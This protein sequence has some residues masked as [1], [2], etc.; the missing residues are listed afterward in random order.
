MIFV[1]EPL[2]EHHAP[3]LIAI[4]NHYVE[5]SFAAYP[6]TP[7]PPAAGAR[8]IEMIAGYPALVALNSSGEVVGFAFLRPWHPA[9]VFRRTAE[10]TYFVAPAQ[11]GQ[12]LGKRFLARLEQEARS[13]G[14]D[15]ILASISSRNEESLAFHRRNGFTECGCFD[16]VGRKWDEDF[17]VV[18]MLK[19][20]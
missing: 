8:W 14:I 10:I 13:R 6:E 4:F 11:R 2:E 17:D 7:L 18:W 16:S 20:I 12:G 15:R 3:D 5:T 19:K 1:L 9:S